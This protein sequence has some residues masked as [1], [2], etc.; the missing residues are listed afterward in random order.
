[1]PRRARDRQLVGGSKAGKLL[2]IGFAWAT[3]AST[4]PPEAGDLKNAAR[5]IYRYSQR[6]DGAVVVQGV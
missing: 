2:T 1:M 6:P 3:V 4:S 5:G